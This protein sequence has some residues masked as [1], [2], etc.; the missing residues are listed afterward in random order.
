MPV[1]RQPLLD[2]ARHLRNQGPVFQPLASWITLLPACAAAR[3]P[4]ACAEIA[5]LPRVPAPRSASSASRARLPL[6]LGT[7]QLLMVRCSCGAISC[8]GPN[9]GECGSSS[10]GTAA[11][12]CCHCRCCFARVRLRV[13]PACGRCGSG[14]RVGAAV[15]GAV[16]LAVCV[17]QTHTVSHTHCD[18]CVCDT[19]CCCPW[20]DPLDGTCDMLSIPPAATAGDPSDQSGRQNEEEE[21]QQRR[22]SRRVNRS[23][24]SGGNMMSRRCRR[25]GSC[26]STAYHARRRRIQESHCHRAGP[27]AAVIVGPASDCRK[28]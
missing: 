25:A 19:V 24:W 23:S 20:W 15:R 9:D 13:S 18:T 1:R 10:G 16:V 26:C 3:V 14:C 12:R 6:L 4:S 22:G 7:V 11:R 27:I 5:P 21:E 2:V 17:C 8:G 28:N